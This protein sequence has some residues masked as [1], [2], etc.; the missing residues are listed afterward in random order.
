MPL[1]EPPI[2]RA[3]VL[4]IIAALPRCRGD[5]PSRYPVATW[6]KLSVNEWVG[7]PSEPRCDACA[8]KSAADITV[9][10]MELEHAP[11][12]RRILGLPIPRP[13]PR[14]KTGSPRDAEPR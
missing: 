3:D 2:A 7:V 11:A 8:A 4:A 14:L 10:F 6:M 5:H 1:A 12:V 9:F 13:S